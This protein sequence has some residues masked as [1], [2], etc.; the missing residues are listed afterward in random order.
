MSEVEE[1]LQVLERQEQSLVFE[2]FD[3]EDAA[4]IG[5][6]MFEKAKEEG[7]SIAIHISLNRREVFHLSMDGCAPD[8]DIWL[9]KKE[10]MV[11]RFLKSSS[12][13]AAFCEQMQTDPLEFYGLD[14]KDYTGAGGGFPIT[15]SGAGC[16]G[17]ICC[18][19]RMPQQDHQMIVDVLTEYLEAR[20]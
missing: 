18:G 9:R 2:K 13:T 3:Q 10:N 20:K 19:G 5:M 8:N 15:V 7:Y 12:R 6:R 1:K 17:A 11:Y 4:A 16:V 14:A